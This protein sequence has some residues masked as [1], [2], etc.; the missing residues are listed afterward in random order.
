ME[1]Q[2]EYKQTE[3][4]QTIILPPLDQLLISLT[5]IIKI[6][7]VSLFH[8]HGR[9]VCQFSPSA[10]RQLAGFEPLMPLLVVPLCCHCYPVADL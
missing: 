9:T 4:K 7:A 8:R 6:I 2:S 5:L 3:H 10:K 1:E